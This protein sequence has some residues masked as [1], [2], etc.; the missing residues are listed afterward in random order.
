MLHNIKLLI[1]YIMKTATI[2]LNLKLIKGLNRVMML[3]PGDMI[4]ATHIA[5]TTWYRIMQSP[6]N[7]S[8]QH[9]LCIANGLHIPV[10]RFFSSSPTD[11]VGLRDDYLMEPY[12][13]CH[14][15][16]AALQLIVETRREAT[17]KRAAE[18][19]GLTRSHLRNSL[20]AVTRTPVTRFLKVCEAFEIDPFTIL[21]D[22]NPGPR[23]KRG[24]TPGSSTN[25]FS[26]E[27]AD[28]RHRIT[29]LS[30]TVADLTT[31]YNDLLNAH[32][33]LAR[34][35]QVNIQNFTDSHLNIHAAEAEPSYH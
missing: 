34:S 30:D 17:W 28:L 11:M 19:T 24:T 27:I 26:A 8:V 12:S 14:Y 33:A 13:D 6:A 31:K 5:S 29:E 2:R 25:D 4:I 10:R 18:A 20:L 21:I 1:Y 22:P 23:R 3:S 9:L 35:I 15:D 7:I 16:D 32:E